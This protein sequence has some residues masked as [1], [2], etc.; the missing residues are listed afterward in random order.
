MAID[1]HREYGKTYD[2]FAIKPVMYLLGLV[3]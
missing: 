1:A 3:L 2:V